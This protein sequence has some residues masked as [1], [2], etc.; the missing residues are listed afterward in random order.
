[1]CN[2]MVS[3]F[4]RNYK[5]QRNE[6]QSR[7]EISDQSISEQVDKSMRR[8]IRVEKIIAVSIRLEQTELQS[9]N[10]PQLCLLQSD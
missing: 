6:R 4:R 5:V 2:V 9:Y 7:S 3:Y 1:M 10:S 8:A